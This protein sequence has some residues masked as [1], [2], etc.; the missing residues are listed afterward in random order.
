MPFYTK[1]HKFYCGI[2][3]HTRMMY[4]CVQEQDG[5]VLV[6]KN[7]KAQATPFLDAVEPFMDDVV[8]GAECTFSWYWLAD[9]CH[10][11]DIPFVLGHALEM[12]LIHGAKSKNDRIDAFKIASLLRAGMLPQAYVYP[13]HLRP[14]RDLLRRRCHLVQLKSEMLTHIQNTNSQY[15]LSPLPGDVR[16]PRVRDE[17]DQHFSDPMV[18]TSMAANIALIDAYDQQIRLMERTVLAQATR[19]RPYDLALLRTVPG[20][21]KILALTLIYEI[22][23]ISRFPSVKKFA[24]YSRLVKGQDISAGKLKGTK[25]A[26]MGNVHLKWAFSEAVVCMMGKSEQARRFIARQAKKGSKGKAMSI[27]S[28]K[29]GRTIYYMLKRKEPFTMARFFAS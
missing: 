19:H 17:L 12:K 20:I 4:L 25:G 18:R 7:I 21:G 24:S 26:K 28:H 8:V 2:D 9:L 1:R 15:N 27:L 22:D 10:D 3:L 6:H 14:T 5:N 13:G 29:L 16:R 11:M 23:D